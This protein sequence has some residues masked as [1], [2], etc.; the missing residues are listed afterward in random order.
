MDAMEVERIAFALAQ[1]L[2]SRTL[3]PDDAYA[4]ARYVAE[5]LRAFRQ[6]VDEGEATSSSTGSCR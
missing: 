1:M 4:W 2:Q 3:P 5:G 6:K